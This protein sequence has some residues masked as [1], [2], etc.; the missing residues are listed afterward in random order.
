LGE[1]AIVFA[2]LFVLWERRD[3]MPRQKAVVLNVELGDDKVRLK[4]ARINIVCTVGE[5]EEMEGKAMV[6]GKV[7]CF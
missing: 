4:H 7:N 6:N 3:G 5:S 1:D 2:V